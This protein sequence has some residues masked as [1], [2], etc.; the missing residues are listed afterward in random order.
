[1]IVESCDCVRRR[2]EPAVGL[3][4]LLG[5]AAVLRLVWALTQVASIENEGAEYCR[6]AENLVSGKGYLGVIA[7]EGL[8][9][10]FPPLYPLL[11]GI[12]SFAFRDFELA[13]RVVSLLAGV[14][15]VWAVY[16]VCRSIYGSA[17]ALIGAALVAMHPVLVALSASVYSEGLYIA[18]MMFALHWALRAARDRLVR[19]GI[20]A[21]VLFGLA[22]LTRPEAL[23]L[24][25]VLVPIL[26]GLGFVWNDPK[27]G[28]AST[29]GLVLALLVV[30][31][32]Y[33]AFLSIN[34]GHPRWEGK[35]AIIYAI[36]Q[37][38]GSG[39]TYSEASYGI[40][41][42]LREEGIHLKSNREVLRSGAMRIRDWE[43][44]SAVARY[45]ATSARRN[46]A[47]LSQ[48]VIADRA[49]GSPMLFVLAV[50]GLLRAPWSRERFTCE[51][52]LLVLFFASLVVLLVGQGHDFRHTLLLLPI[53]IIWAAK[54]I[55][56]FGEWAHGT[57]VALAPRYSNGI[58]I[59]LRCLIGLMLLGVSLSNVAAV[60]EFVQSKSVSLKTAGRWLERYAP[61]PK[62]ILGTRT[63][64]PY[65]A[66]G[67]LWYLPYAESSLALRYVEKKNPD[68]IVLQSPG[69]RPFE[70]SW[71]KDGIP[72]G[73]AR[74][75]YSGGSEPEGRVMIYRWADRH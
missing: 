30:A 42:D 52:M 34:A 49:F 35:G 63:A 67:D 66:R 5:V 74:L 25:L 40:D 7:N 46:L 28:A 62:T 6:L 21:G 53:L 59:A 3:L 15:L 1:M 69:L 56:E 26:L 27:K 58:G 23:F 31:S 43:S 38:V 32:P 51:A 75:I 70:E 8:Q 41:K 47:D 57:A 36:G 17:V 68:F 73:K 50:L 54:G 71:M 44:M 9:L 19:A 14:G 45:F 48:V 39:L 60:G 12:F 11:I 24:A 72:D 65:Y 64:V 61:G 2:I 16:L 18:L 10:N 55:S 33:I 37:R 13:A 4:L 29:A 22:Y 20:I